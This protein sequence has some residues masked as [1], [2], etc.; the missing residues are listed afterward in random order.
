[1]GMKRKNDSKEDESAS[2]RTHQPK[3]IVISD[4]D[5]AAVNSKSQPQSHAMNTRASARRRQPSSTAATPSTPSASATRAQ[6]KATATARP[7]TQRASE[8]SITPQ[9]KVQRRSTNSPKKSP[10]GE[11]RLR[12]F[13]NH[14]PQSFLIKL[15]R[16]ATQRWV[17]KTHHPLQYGREAWAKVADQVFLYSA[18]YVFS[19]EA[20]TA[21][22]KRPSR[23]SK[24][25]GALGMYTP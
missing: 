8:T 18:G 10:E 3:V 19:I 21:L 12:Q 1:M 6:A 7:R 11:K 25:Q 14:A 13:R 4:D 15:E 17:Y 23:P 16:A 9:R 5:D 24:L 2:P 20:K 22:R